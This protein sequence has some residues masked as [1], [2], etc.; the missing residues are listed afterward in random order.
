MTKKDRLAFA[1]LA[2]LAQFIAVGRAHADIFW[3]LWW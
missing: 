2:V 3:W 1:V